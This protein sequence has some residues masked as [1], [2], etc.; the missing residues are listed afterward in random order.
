MVA[1]QSEERALDSGGMEKR[2]KKN[3]VFNEGKS[4]STK[5]A[6]VGGDPARLLLRCL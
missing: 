5:M 3:E 1:Q 4:G 2:E 6:I